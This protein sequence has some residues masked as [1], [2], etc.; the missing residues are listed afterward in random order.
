MSQATHTEGPA[1]SPAES[2][3]G[4]G[5]CAW[6]EGHARGV[7]LVRIQEQSGNGNG[8]Y[9]ACTPCRQAYDL[10]PLADQP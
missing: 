3:T 10:T 1:E 5:W 4:Y 2:S 7:R 6:H 9:F 8:S